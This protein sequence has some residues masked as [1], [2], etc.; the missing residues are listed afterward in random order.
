MF[1]IHRFVLSSFFSLFHAETNFDVFFL[2]SANETEK[3]QKKP[4]TPHEI[5]EIDL[6]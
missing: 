6:E 3:K 5:D 2:R 1:E 4:H